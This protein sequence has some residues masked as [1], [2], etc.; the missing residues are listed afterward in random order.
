MAKYAQYGDKKMDL[1]ELTLERAKEIMARF[2]PEL[3]E[4]KIETKKDGE[5]T[6]YVFTKQAGR[7]GSVRKKRT[8]AK[9]KPVSRIASN[10]CR[11]RPTT[12]VPASAIAF[13]GREIPYVP[14][15]DQEFLAQEIRATQRAL[16]ML[17]AATPQLPRG[18]VLL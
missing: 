12:V 13:D 4:P 2:F 10:L 1:G 9:H 5:D 16:H 15:A 14:I 8:Q 3:A 17:D 6:V 18:D 11:L 7:K